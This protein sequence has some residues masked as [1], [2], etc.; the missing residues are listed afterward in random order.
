MISCLGGPFNP[1]A[2]INNAV[3]NLICSLVFGH[4][5]DYKNERFTKLMEKFDRS[6]EIEGSIWAQ[7]VKSLYCIIYSIQ[8]YY[9]AFFYIIEYNL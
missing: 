5:F 2:I 4:R 7:V 6:F 3:S 1:H 8:T 9:T